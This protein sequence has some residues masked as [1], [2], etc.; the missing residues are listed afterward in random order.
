MRKAVS[1][2][3]GL[4]RRPPGDFWMLM[5]VTAM[6]VACRAALRIAPFRKVHSFVEKPRQA[7]VSVRSPRD[8]YQIAWAASTAGKWLLPNRPCLTQALVLKYLYDRRG[9]PATLR[10]GVKKSDDNKLLAH[11]WVESN[12]QVVI[13]GSTSPDEYRAFPEFRTRHERSAVD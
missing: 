4:T 9:F 2:T 5:K 7:G 10:I 1:R 13:G 3:V 8:A 12:G 6:T 11:A